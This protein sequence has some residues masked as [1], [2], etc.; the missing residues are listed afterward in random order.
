[1]KVLELFAGSR[2]IG[3]ACEE[4]GYEVFSVDIMQFE[5]IDY[6]V[7][8]LDFDYSKV[9]FTPDVIWASPPCTSFSVASI[10][11]HWNKDRTPKS[12]K[13]ELGVAIAKKTLEVINHYIRLNP[14]MIYYI[15]NPRGML[16]KMDFMPSHKHTV[17]YCQYGDSRMKPTDI[18]TNNLRWTPKQP[19]KNGSPCHVSAP[20]GSSTGTQGL[21]G[22]YERSKIPHAL[23]LEVLTQI[24]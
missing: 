8:I 2:S 19:C 4:L 5:N 23:C 13:A 12:E 21:K 24:K 7:D 3:K 11:R 10:G 22:N 9:P 17:T 16:R 15:E 6:A 14:Y 1:M 20:R 18:W